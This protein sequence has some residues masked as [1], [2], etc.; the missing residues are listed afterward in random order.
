MKTQWWPTEP[1]VMTL[2]L[3][4]VLFAGAGIGTESRAF[5]G[6]VVADAY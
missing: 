1:G 2:V 3:L 4:L 5:G 6:S